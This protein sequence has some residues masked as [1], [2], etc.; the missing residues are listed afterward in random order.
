M[1]LSAAK[2]HELVLFYELYS[3]F[4]HWLQNDRFSQQNLMYLLLNRGQTV[5]KKH[6]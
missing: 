2:I 6:Y 5:E 1:R 4:E 3:S